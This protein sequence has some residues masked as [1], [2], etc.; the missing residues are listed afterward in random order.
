MK[1]LL[2][3]QFIFL[4]ESGKPEVYS[5]GG[6][7][8]V[9]RGLASKFLVLAAVR[10]NDHLELRRIV[11]DFKTELI[12]DPLLKKYFSTAYSLEA[13]H[14]T[15]DFPEIRER[16][17]RFLN[18]LD[19]RIDVVVVD[20][21][22]CYPA[23]R[24][25]PGRMYGVM[26]GQLLRDLCH[27]TERTEII[28]S[29]KDSKLKL[30]RELETEVECVRLDYLNKHPNLRADL[31]L[32]YQHN[33]HYTHAGLQVADYA[34]FAVFKVFET[35]EDKWYRLVQGKIGRIQDVCNKKYFTKSNPL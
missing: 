13:F 30:R 7:N 1:E 28:F 21:M 18:D 10:S 29:R 23:L 35:G 2:P 8:L 27:Q 15:D 32:T 19:I 3:Q 20:K 31:R 25:N 33:P 12:G 5:S 17:Y 14:A 4:D 26:A 34:A 16:F 24:E 11:G 9:E 6:I 22:K